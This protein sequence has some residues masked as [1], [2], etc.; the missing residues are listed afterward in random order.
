MQIINDLVKWCLYL[1]YIASTI[2]DTFHQDILLCGAQPT[3]YSPICLWLTCWEL[4]STAPSTSFTWE[5]GTGSLGTL[6]ANLSL[7]SHT[8]PFCLLYSP[9]L[10]LPMK[11]NSWCIYSLNNVFLCKRNIKSPT[12]RYLTVCQNSIPCTLKKAFFILF[13]IWMTSFILAFPTLVF[14]TVVDYG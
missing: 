4:S 7:L 9:W 13:V 3:C 1:I 12:C 10:P 6:A 14:S 8:L 5:T 11:G 2:L